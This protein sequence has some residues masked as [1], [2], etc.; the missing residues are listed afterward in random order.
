MIP[1]AFAPIGPDDLQALIE[2]QVAESRTLDYKQKY[3]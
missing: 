1:K 2:N 3:G